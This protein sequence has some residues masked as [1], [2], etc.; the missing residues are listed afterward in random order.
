MVLLLNGRLEKPLSR[1]ATLANTYPHSF[2]SQEYNSHARAHEPT[3]STGFVSYGR[4]LALVRIPNNSP[5][6]VA[7]CI[8]ETGPMANG[9][10]SAHGAMQ[11]H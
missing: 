10:R 7:G 2:Y 3:H 9:K 11:L 8:S 6:L 4:V 5:W 1:L